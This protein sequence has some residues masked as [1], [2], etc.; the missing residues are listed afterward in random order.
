MKLAAPLLVTALPALLLAGSAAAQGTPR[1]VYGRAVLA[2]DGSPQ[3]YAQDPRAAPPHAGGTGGHQGLGLPPTLGYRQFWGYAGFGQGIG[4][5]GLAVGQSAGQAELYVG[6]STSTFGADDYWYA[7]QWDAATSSMRQ[8]YVSPYF[9]QGIAHVAAGDVDPKPGAEIVVLASDGWVSI[10]TQS[11][12]GLLRSFHL[13]SAAIGLDLY[14]LDGDG[15]AELLI[16]DSFTVTALDGL[17]QVAWSAAGG[18]SGVAVGQMDADPALEIATGDGHVVE[19]PSGAV[20]CTLPNLW[21]LSVR[22]ADF[23]GDG[24]DEV[25][26]AYPWSPVLAYDVDTCQQKWSLPIFNLGAMTIAD[27]DGDGTDELILGDAQWGAVHGHSLV[28]TQQLWSIGNPEHG[29][30]NIAVTD[31]DGDGANDVLW[32]S[33]AT[34]TGSDRLYVG[35]A[36]APAIGWQNVQLDG[37]F[38]GPALGDV[39]GDGLQDLV[40]CSATSDAGYRAGRIVVID[41]GDYHVKAI[42]QEIANGLGWTG[43][44]DLR[45]HDIDGDGNQEIVVADGTTYDGLIEIWDVSAAGAFTR[46]FVNQTLPSGAT[47]YCAAVGDVDG[48]GHLEVVG[49]VGREHTGALGTFVYV[50]DLATGA[51][52][53]HSGQLGGYWDRISGLELADTDNVPGLEIVAMVAG[54]GVSVFDGATKAPEGGVPGTFTALRVSQAIQGTQSALWLGDTAGGLYSYLWN[55]GAYQFSSFQL[56]GAGP[57]DGFDFGRLHS[58]WWSSQGNLTLNTAPPFSD[59]LWTGAGYGPGFGKRTATLPHQNAVITAGAYA[60]IGF[61]QPH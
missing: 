60:L 39:D 41:A 51:E 38:V 25:V 37:P 18:G 13:P 2:A 7:L 32:G 28:T 23:D 4:I 31:V 54:G 42:S 59:S 47:F 33:G 53:W 61:K 14:D 35:D 50:Y 27:G 24:M 16:T 22:A 57:I 49:G 55:G 36:T 26:F 6:A 5:A 46:V 3:N 19:Y 21:A 10:L 17:G 11:G 48:D 30:T 34:S 15:L 1:D 12:K 45:L 9:A 29:T 40:A 20:Q 8:T 44:H 58:F 43:I 56:L 52:E